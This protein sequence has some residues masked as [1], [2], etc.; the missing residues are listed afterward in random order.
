[1]EGYRLSDESTDGFEARLE[2]ISRD[3]DDVEFRGGI[4]QAERTA[5][6]VEDLMARRQKKLEVVDERKQIK[7]K[8]TE[9]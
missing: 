5:V 4:T 1:M 6:M 9:E 7:Q 8:L 2:A 3:A